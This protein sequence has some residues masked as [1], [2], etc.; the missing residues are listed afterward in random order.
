[1]LISIQQSETPLNK[2]FFSDYNVDIV[3]RGIKQAF[4]NTTGISIDTQNKGDLLAIMRAAFINNTGDHFKDVNAQVKTINGI[5]IN[6]ALKQINSGVNQYIG[7]M[8][9]VNAP[10]STVAAPLNTST[11]GKKINMKRTTNMIGIN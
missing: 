1:M 8:R 11:V 3:S 2:L 5:T 4:K 7:Y 9:T 10:I 6:M